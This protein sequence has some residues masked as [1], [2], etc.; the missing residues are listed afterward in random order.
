MAL[1]DD[2]TENGQDEIYNWKNAQ[3]AH[4]PELH[5]DQGAGNV[6]EMRDP[7]EKV[8]A[9]Y[10][11][12]LAESPVASDGTSGHDLVLDIED[13]DDMNDSVIMH[14]S[15]DDDDGTNPSWLSALGVVELSSPHLESM[16]SII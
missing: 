6:P 11:P 3:E 15:S 14:V 10:A 12:V 16:L 8:D 1:I 13:V 7:D 9:Q 4:M 5:G 2:D